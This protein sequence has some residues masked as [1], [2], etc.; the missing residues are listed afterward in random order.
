[1]TYRPYT[2]IVNVAASQVSAIRSLLVNNSGSAIPALIP[3]RLNSTGQLETID[4][5]SES[6]VMSI[7]GVTEQIIADWTEGYVITQGK[8]ENI[9]TG[10]NFGDYIYVSKTGTLTNVYPTV[11]VAGFIAG[12]FAIRVG[13]IAKNDTFPLQKD[14]FI[15]LAIIGQL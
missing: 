15:S 6:S 13:V 8:H 3:V 4:V 9:T 2:D 7:V 1:M 10:F 12:D 14:V 5:S 11:G